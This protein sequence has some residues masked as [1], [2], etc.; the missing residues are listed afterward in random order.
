MG[1][2]AAGVKALK[3]G[4]NDAVISMVVVKRESTLFIATENGFGKRSE[5]Q[6][7]RTMH[8]GGKGVI[9]MKT[10][11]RNGKVV[12]AIEVLDNDELLL[13]A[14]SGTMMR[15]AAADLRVIGRN[16]AGVRLMNLKEDDNLIDVAIIAKEEI[17]ENGSIPERE[18]IA[19]NNEVFKEEEN[20]SGED[21]DEE[22]EE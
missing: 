2:G 12:N 22:T 1:R 7:Y 13:V 6:D 18:P 10:S 21:I 16:T 11:D 17:E 5:M 3:L 4:K 14:Q 9:T 8:R 20:E 19:E 15:I